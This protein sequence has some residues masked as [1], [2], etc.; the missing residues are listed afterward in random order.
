MPSDLVPIL[1]IVGI[2]VGVLLIFSIVLRWYKKVP[3]D[4]AGVVTGQRKRVITGGGGFV[5]PVFERIDFISLGNIPLKVTTSNSLSSQGVP[6]NVTTTAVIKVKNEEQSILTAIEQFVGKNERE[7][8]DNISGT[9]I[10]VL[11]GKLREIIAGMTVEDLYNSREKFRSQV[12]EVVGIEFGGMGLEI[13]NFTITDITD[14][15]GY[16]DAMGEGRIAERRRDSEVQKANA[17]K[18]QHIQVAQAEREGD[19]ARIN[20]EKAIAEAEKDK[21]L[22][23]AEFTKETER[24][25][26]EQEKAYSIQANISQKDVTQAELDVVLLQQQRQKEITEAEIAVKIAAE[27]KNIELAEKKAEQKK[28]ALRAEVIEPAEAEKEKAKADAEAKKLKDVAEAEAQ[29]QAMRLKA[30]AEADAKKI[31][32]EAEAQAIKLKGQAQAEAI[33]AEGLAE[34]E[35]LEKKAEAQAKMGQASVLE[36]IIGVLP[37]MATAIAKPLEQVDKITIIGGDNSDGISQVSSYVPTALAKT[38]ESIRETTGFDLLN[39][40]KANTYDGVVNKNINIS[41]VVSDEVDVSVESEAVN[42]ED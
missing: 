39:V 15:N 40:M 17:L 28:A 29:A 20:K 37:Q 14:D 2:V 10:S 22:K 42:E 26:A 19:I 7:I 27:Q 16:I 9:A 18:D 38:I 36:M 21:N 34:A 11:E 23:V 1:P 13:K 5:I 32:A 12:E 25:R 8:V 6:I 30:Q 4:K 35:A 3:Q 31:E 41:G 24:A 33:R